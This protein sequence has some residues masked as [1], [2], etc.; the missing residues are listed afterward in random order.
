MADIYN[1]AELLDESPDGNGGSVSLDP[2][3]H[4]RLERNPFADSVNPEF[5]FRTEAHENAYAE[6]RKCFEKDVAI[7]LTTAPSGTGKT[8]LTQILLTEMKP[9]KYEVPL[10]LAYPGLKQL[11]LL[12]EIARELG[13]GLR[14]RHGTAEIIAAIQ[15]KIVR[16]YEE[17]RK[18]V[19]LIDECHFL[20]LDAL[21]MVRTL[22]NLELP[23]RK[24]VTILLFGEESFLQKMGRPGFESIFNRIFVRCSLRSLSLEETEQ[25]VKFRT[26]V[27]GGGADMMAADFY[28]ALHAQAKGIP[29][30]INRL[31]FG[32]LHHAARHGQKRVGAEALPPV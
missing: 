22:S 14:S 24:L 1:V 29:R 5:F 19:I 11:A 4:F 6:M 21:Q 26:L 10:V 18:L 15:E 2:V 32:A 31:C 23:D 13:I 28:L 17:R 7:G 8:L 30:D 9:E 12:R 3:K 27:C 25:Y 20:G 16:L